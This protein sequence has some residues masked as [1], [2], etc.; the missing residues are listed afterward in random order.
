MR[1]Y[2]DDS[3]VDGKLTYHMG[4]EFAHREMADYWDFM[5]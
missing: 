5:Y 1:L 2:Y 3:V 4:L